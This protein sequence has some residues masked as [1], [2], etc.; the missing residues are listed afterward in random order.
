VGE[1]RDREEPDLTAPIHV[2]EP[3]LAD[4][5]GHC[6][7]FVAAVCGSGPE[8]RFEL[9]ADRQAEPA[10]FAELPQI[11]LHPH[12][13]RRL[14]RPQ[15]WLLYRRLLEQPGKVFLPTAGATDITLLCAAA[16][17]PLRPG[18]AACFVHWIR[19][20]A[21]RQRRLAA[22][23]RRQPDLG[24]LGPTE[25]I[26]DFLRTA[27]FR[28][29]AYVPYPISP[30][31][32]PNAEP[33]GFGH[34]LFAG[35]AR[36]DKGFDRVVDLIEVLAERGES[37]PV[38][39]QTSARHYGKRDPEIARQLARL[40]RLRYPSLHEHSDTLDESAYFAQFQGAICLQPYVK[41]EFA[42]R[43][44][45]VTVDALGCGAPVVTTAG[46]W[47]GRNV[48]RLGAGLAVP[49]PTGPTLHQALRQLIDDYPRY[50]V[51]ARLAARTIHAEHAPRHLL[52][53]VLDRGP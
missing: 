5:T 24:V 10:L 20:T 26:V 17:A 43:V 53:A 31:A 3:T 15:A 11:E 50:S 1:G 48:E 22:A 2:V 34:V 6:T 36:M 18:K 51:A 16:K 29:A 7:S 14:R 28:R 41:D 37:L 39:L 33:S 49:D 8:Q 38:H 4:A 47:M 12:L 30:C 35:A 40:A 44:S 32:R 13:Q 21:S 9:W 27:G 45:A 19:P 25:E 42:H 46:T 23:A 52:E